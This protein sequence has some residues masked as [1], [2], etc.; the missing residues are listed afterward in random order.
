M[1]HR[2]C[3]CIRVRPSASGSIRPSTV[4]TFPLSSFLVIRLQ[5]SSKGHQRNSDPS[6]GRG[7]AII[8]CR[9]FYGV[10][11]H[12]QEIDRGEMQ[13][14]ECSHGHGKGSQSTLED[15]RRELYESHTADQKTGFIC[16]RASKLARMHSG[17]DLILHEPAGDQ[18]LAPQSSGWRA[19]LGEQV[20]KSHRRVEIDHRSSRA[21]PRSAR[22]SLKLAT[23]L[24]GG[25]RSSTR[26]GGVTQPSRTAS[27]SM[28][29]ASMG[30][31]P[32]WGGTS[33]ATTRSRSVTST[34]SPLA[35][36]RTYSLSLFFRTLMPT[37]RI[38]L[39]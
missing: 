28:A 10:T 23:G 1:S 4:W 18:R 29:S 35:A 20:G 39:K 27:A 13:G 19:V 30:L 6:R 22:I 2:T 12:A 26:V 34:T 3:S 14:V 36:K 32:A 33:S 16:V 24:R 15:R 9:K 11:A 21:R 8:I 7:Q 25:G 37:A 5:H 38:D 17:P 31:R